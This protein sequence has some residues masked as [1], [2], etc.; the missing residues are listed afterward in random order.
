MKDLVLF[1][2]DCSDSF[3]C[4]Y[5]MGGKKDMIYNMV[6]IK[7]QV[8]NFVFNKVYPTVYNLYDNKLSKDN[9]KFLYK[10]GIIKENYSYMKIMEMLDVSKSIL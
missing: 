6:L 5:N 3:Q 4:Y 1:I 9:E 8:E 7:S 2:E 10:Q